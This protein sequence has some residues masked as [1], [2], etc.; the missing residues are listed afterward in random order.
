MARLYALAGADPRAPPGADRLALPILGADRLREMSSAEPDDVRFCLAVSR[1]L[2]E[3]YQDSEGPLP[4]PVARE[5]VHTVAIPDPAIAVSV[6]SHLSVC[7][8]ASIFAV[9]THVV[10][11]RIRRLFGP[12][13]SGM[14]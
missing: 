1:A 14:E 8:I 11:W 4:Y 3:W 2:V 10:R 9:S 12:K 7:D 13:R 6:Y 5:M